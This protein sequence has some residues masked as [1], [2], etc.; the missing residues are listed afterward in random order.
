MA[1]E[2][3]KHAIV[4]LVRGFEFVAEFPDLPGSPAIL[5][6]EPSPL[7]DGRAPNA[8]SGLAAA[9]GNCLSASLVVCLAGRCKQP[10][11]PLRTT[12]HGELVRNDKGRMRIGHL[13]VTIHLLDNAA[14][15]Q[16]FERCLAQFEDF[17]VVTESVRHGIP[18]GVRVVDA[19][20]AQ[21]F[22][23]PR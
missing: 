13:D 2:L 14:D 16:H 1:D 10:L 9:V 23:A 11:G 19:G 6:D 5:L 22:A 3:T 17:C 20:G 7:G 15:V 18:V 21:V 4:H 8:A 12:V